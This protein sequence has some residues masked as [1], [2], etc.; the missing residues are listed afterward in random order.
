MPVKTLPS[1]IIG[2]GSNKSIVNNI[3]NNDFGNTIIT[4]Y[5]TV[6]YYLIVDGNLT[7]GG[8]FDLAGSFEVSGDITVKNPSDVTVFSVD[9]ATGDTLTKGDITVKNPSDVTVFSVDSATGDTLTK[10]DLS[11]KSPSDVTVFSVD[12]ATGDTLTK[13]DITVKNPSDVTVFSVDSATGDTLTKGDLSVKSPSDVTVFSVDSATGDTL[14]KGDITVKNVSNA[15]VFSVDSATG[16]TIVEGNLTINGTTTTIDSVTLVVEDPVIT[17]AKNANSDPTASTDAGLFLQRGSTENPAIFI[18]NETLNQFEI[19]TVTGA[20]S[21]TTNFTGGSVTKTYATLKAGT[22]YGSDLDISGLGGFGSITT[23]SLSIGEHTFNITGITLGEYGNLNINS[24]QD[25]SSI[26]LNY[27]VTSGVPSDN[28][29]IEVKRGSSTS[30][31]IT[32]DESNDRWDFNFGLY[33]NTDSQIK[34]EKPTS[35]TTPVILLNADRTGAGQEAGVVALEVERGTETNSYLKWD[36]TT[37]S[38]EFS[39][40]LVLNESLKLNNNLVPVYLYVRYVSTSLAD[41]EYIYIFS[42]QD[43]GVTRDVIRIASL[44]GS[45]TENTSLGYYRYKASTSTTYS[46]GNPPIVDG[47]IYLDPNKTYYFNMDSLDIQGFDFQVYFSTSI[48]ATPPTYRNVFEGFSVS[49][50][51]ANIVYSLLSNVNFTLQDS[52]IVRR[53]DDGVVEINTLSGASTVANLD[54][55]PISMESKKENQTNTVILFNSDTTGV[56]SKS[57]KIEIERGTSTNSFIEWNETYG[58]WTISPTI[59]SNLIY[60]TDLQVGYSTFNYL[61]E[62]Q[63]EDPIIVVKNPSLDATFSV[64]GGGDIESP[65]GHLQYNKETLSGSDNLIPVYIYVKYG[66]SSLGDDEY[67]YIFTTND[68]G[69]TREIVRLYSLSNLTE[70][71]SGGHYSYLASVQAAYNNTTPTPT[72]NA[73]AYIDPNKTYY[74]YQETTG[75]NYPLSTDFAIYVS[76]SILGSLLSSSYRNVFLSGATPEANYVYLFK[77]DTTWQEIDI[78]RRVENNGNLI[79]GTLSASSTLTDRVEKDT[80]IPLKIK[81]KLE[82]HTNN[83][84]ILLNSDETGSP[85]KSVQI[86]VERGTETNS[87]IKWSEASYRWEIFSNLK[88]LDSSSNTTLLT[89]DSFIYTYKSLSLQNNLFYKYQRITSSDTIYSDV[90]FVLIDASGIINVNLPSIASDSS[91]GRVLNI[92]VKSP[93]SV[94]LYTNVSGVNLIHC[95]ITYTPADAFILSGYSS[96]QLVSYTQGTTIKEWYITAISNSDQIREITT[97]QDLPIFNGMVYHCNPPA[98]IGLSLG[99]APNGT[100]LTFRSISAQTTTITTANNGIEGAHNTITL[101]SNSEGLS[102]YYYGSSWWVSSM[103]G[104]VGITTVP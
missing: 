35:A 86:E 40:S 65:Y 1:V 15:T 30:S 29:V 63:N 88:V 46:N 39:N 56:P 93:Y 2:S 31:K 103:Y 67:F 53:V 80:T 94:N 28:A 78:V 22:I 74:F 11:V 25:Y 76:S 91:G 97:S 73:I 100:K 48:E 44:S 92:K 84:A 59:N 85:T 79:T 89:D 42:T 32:W 64:N 104:N 81:K 43:N 12:S 5:L 13:G 34:L 62:Y 7:V 82:L 47:I 96:I 3:Y 69:V 4:G 8:S 66:A 41:N 49:T 75:V 52:N 17:L 36:E 51:S 90:S 87:Y 26:I 10:G 50:T 27:N 38:W 21:T 23:G 24:V 102:I 60:S 55:I 98:G 18:W 20:T 9:S 61:G 16:D 101:N 70:Y 95:G 54:I 57:V 6:D 72:V 45:L 71:T 37:D 83:T 68:N 19:A 58:F 14:T 99:T 77:Y 33:L